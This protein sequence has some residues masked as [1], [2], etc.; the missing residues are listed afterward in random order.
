[1]ALP[2]ITLRNTKGSALTHTEMDT[3][4]TNLQQA[5]IQVTAAG[6]TT[7]I[8]LGGGFTL[9][10]GANIGLTNTA[11]NI[12]ITNTQAAGGGGL[13]NVVEDTSP[14]LGGNLDLNGF[15]ITSANPFYVQ[16]GSEIGDPTKGILNS[17][18]KIDQSKPIF[19]FGLTDTSSQSK[20][21]LGIQG[22]SDGPMGINIV[23]GN[24]AATSGSSMSHILLS[25]SVVVDEYT[26]LELVK[27]GPDWVGTSGLSADIPNWAPGDA[28]LMN[29]GYDLR[30]G[31]SDL[32]GAPRGNVIFGTEAVGSDT[33]TLDLSGTGDVILHSG[34]LKLA[35][36]KGIYADSGLI[37]GCDDVIL[38]QGVSGVTPEV[39]ITTVGGQ[40]LFFDT[41]QGVNT[42]SFAITAGVN[43]NIEITPNGTG[44]TVITNATLDYPDIT[45]ITSVNK[46]T[47][48]APATSATLTIA[49]GKTLT[50]SNT[51]TLAGTDSTVMTFPPTSSTIGYLNMPQ[52][53]LTAFTGTRGFELSDSGKHIYTFDGGET[54]SIPVSSNI[55]FPLGTVITVVNHSTV[56]VAI[57]PGAVS[58]YLAGNTSAGSRTITSHGVATLIKVASDTWFINGTGVV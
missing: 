17:V 15:N 5:N 9:S 25:T 12:T 46:V 32:S 24:L 16:V 41:N 10:A 52:V 22:T 35:V 31:C 11:G 58:L 19:I 56:N 55:A 7:N 34:N 39:A 21:G 42:G 33:L 27:L 18:D 29:F 54:L 36:G 30:I 8:A 45:N 20:E 57:S 50:A 13:A 1:M 51:I 40:G 49:N 44:R 6:T 2:A 48:T 4:L 26:A 3:N 37:I 53:N 38:G 23:S 14:Q 28:G 43:G 47:I